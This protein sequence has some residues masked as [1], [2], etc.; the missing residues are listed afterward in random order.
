MTR[1]SADL[2]RHTVNCTI[3]NCTKTTR[4]C[5]LWLF[6]QV[7]AMLRGEP[8][9]WEVGGSNSSLQLTL[10]RKYFMA[11]NDLDRCTEQL[12]VG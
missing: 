12:E 2:T 1:C 4:V 10:G 11:T 7:E 3:S 8:A 9:P 5:H 6:A